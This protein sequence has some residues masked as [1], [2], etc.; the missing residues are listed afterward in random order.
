MCTPLQNHKRFLLNFNKLYLNIKINENFQILTLSIH[1][2][3]IICIIK[4]FSHQNE[5]VNRR[6]KIAKELTSFSWWVVNL[7]LTIFTLVWN[8]WSELP[9]ARET[10]SIKNLEGESLWCPT[11]LTPTRKFAGWKRVNFAYNWFTSCCGRNQ[12]VEGGYGS[13]YKQQTTIYICWSFR[14]YLFTISTL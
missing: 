4:A 8:C 13:R 5:V 2:S 10:I 14:A 11:L 6:K 9:W 3:S 1:V 7:A 12:P